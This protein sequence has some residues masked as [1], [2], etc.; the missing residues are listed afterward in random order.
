MF[1]VFNTILTV[2]FFGLSLN[3]L[4]CDTSSNRYTLGQE[5][6]SGAHIGYCL[7][8][9]FVIAS[10]F[11]QGGINWYIYYNKNPF[12]TDFLA[13]YDNNAVLGKFFIKIIPIIYVTI[14]F[15]LQYV[16]VFAFGIA[17][18]LCGYIF[19]FRIFAFHDYNEK[20]FYFV[21]FL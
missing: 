20:N 16:D 17:G 4:Y 21:L 1:L 3:V 18:C 6:Y 9:G 7:L 5:C 11:I 19:F 13:K 8:A 14:D 2:P 10:L 12:A 15:N